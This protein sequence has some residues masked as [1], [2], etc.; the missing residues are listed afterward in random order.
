MGDIQALRKPSNIPPVTLE[1]LNDYSEGNKDRWVNSH[2]TGP[3]IQYARAFN[4]NNIFCIVD[5]GDS[6]TSTL[7]PSSDCNLFWCL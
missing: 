5:N 3:S 7:L 1:E 2:K 4:D 6:V